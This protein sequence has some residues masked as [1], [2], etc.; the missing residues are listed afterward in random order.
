M[1]K[2]QYQQTYEANLI[3]KGYVCINHP[4]KAATTT[5]KTLCYACYSSKRWREDAEYK[6]KQIE[7][8]KEYVKNNRA[9]INAIAKKWRDNN[10]EKHREAVRKSIAKRK[11]REAGRGNPNE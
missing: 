3:A 2:R 8:H 11:E 9:R 6:A 5:K 10:P 7:R 1:T 4:E